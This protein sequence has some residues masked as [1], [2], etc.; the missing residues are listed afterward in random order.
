MSISV[1]APTTSPGAP[2]TTT[3]ARTVE[4]VQALREVWEATPVAVLDADLDFFLTVV[5]HAPWVVRPHVV[6]VARPG[7]ADLL[8]VARIEDVELPLTLGYR[9]LRRR[10]VRA[11]VLAFGGLLGG[12]CPADDDLMLS[13]LVAPLLAGEAGVLLLRQVEVGSDLA[14]AVSRAAPWWRRLHGQRATDRWIAPVPDTVERFLAR[15]SRRSRSKLR[16]LDRR[17]VKDYGDRLRIRLFRRPEELEQLEIDLE[18]VAATSY[19]RRLGA[20]H[21]GDALDH[22]LLAVGLRHGWLSAWVM[23]VD[24]LPVAFWHGTTYA[25]TFAT[26]TPAFDPRLAKDSVGRFTMLRMVTDLCADPEVKVL[27]FGQGEAVYKQA[28][29]LAARREVDLR[30]VAPRPF[31]IVP[32]LVDSV[33]SATQNWAWRQVRHTD[34]GQQIRADARRRA[35][36]LTPADD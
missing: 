16:N 6:H 19:Q 31:Q 3:V 35:G 11:V 5:Q 36:V 24:D 20:G 21:R 26:W 18:T 32:N 8:V 23:Y 29:A 28:F 10:R 15:R 33:F 7:R 14:R 22:E 34:L 25:G 4:Q 1:S 27:D 2:W 12:E 30:V 17:L 13:E 9:V